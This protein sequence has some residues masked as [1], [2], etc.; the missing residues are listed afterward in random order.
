MKQFHSISF[1][2]EKRQPEKPAQEML[3]LSFF[4]QTMCQ[5]FTLQTKNK[6]TFC[7]LSCFIVFIAP[8]RK[9]NCIFLVFLPTSARLFFYRR[10]TTAMRQ[11]DASKQWPKTVFA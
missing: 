9:A 4:A 1:L 7:F 11:G 6:L 8:L 10:T 3:G 5:L 2:R